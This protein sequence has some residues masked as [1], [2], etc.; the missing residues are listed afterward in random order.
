[1][2]SFR[3]FGSG[4]QPKIMI[5]YQSEWMGQIRGLQSSD[6]LQKALRQQRFEKE[7][8]FQIQTQQQLVRD[9]KIPY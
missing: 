9:K 1:M 4:W 5:G 7:I 6:K 3:I 8:K 2:I